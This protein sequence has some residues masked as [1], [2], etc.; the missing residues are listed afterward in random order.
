MR[1]IREALLFIAFA[2]IVTTLSPWNRGALIR[3]IGDNLL[4]G[5][6]NLAACE[7]AS[8]E[9]REARDIRRAPRQ[10]KPEGFPGGAATWLTRGLG[11]IFREKVKKM[12]T[13]FGHNR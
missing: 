4:R 11:I 2:K 7:A 1:V 13:R 5:S 10:P 6:P 9:E 12:L 3:H 8:P